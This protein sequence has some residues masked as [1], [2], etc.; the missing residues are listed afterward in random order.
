MA[1]LSGLSGCSA[2]AS[3]HS[4]QA[5]ATEDK[6]A[7]SKDLKPITVLY[8]SNS[9]T[10]KAY[11]EEMETNAS[12]YGFRVHVGTVDSAT[13]HVPKDKPVLIIEP[14]YE[15][16]PADNAKKFTSW[17]QAN[18]DSNSLD[19]V[20]YA[21]FGVGNSDW[22]HT[23]HRVPKLTDELMNKMGGRRFLPFGSV[24]VKL[25]IVG[26]WEEWQDR[27]WASLRKDYG[28]TSRV[29]SSQLQA[30]ITPPKF[31]T[32]LGGSDIGY[33]VVKVNR[34]L[35]GAEVG[36][37]KKHM[38]IELPIGTS[39]RP[40]DYMVVLPLNNITMVKRVMKRFELSPNDN[41][42]VTGTNKAFIST[43]TP[44]S[45]FDLL[46]S[47]VELGTPI[48]QKQIRTLAE[49]MPEDKCANLLEVA[50][51]PLYTSNTVAKRFNIIDILEDFSECQL[52][53]ATYLDML[54]PL[55]PRQYSISSSPLAN[56]EF[57]E[58]PQGSG[59]RLTASLTYD[60]HDTGAWSGMGRRF[61]G[62]AS[63]YLARQEPGEK[64]RCFTRA[65]NV[66]FHLPLDPTIPIIMVCAG[67]G[68][69][70]MRG[71]IQE[72]ATIQKARNI[73]LGPA[74]LYFGCRNYEF[75]YIYADELRQWETDGVV[76]VR[77]CFSQNA[78]A[79]AS[80]QHVPDQMWTDREEL[81]ELFGERKGKIFICGS[82]SKLAKSTAE[83]C[84][85][86]WLERNKGLSEEDAQKW[87]D[88]VKEDRYVTDVYD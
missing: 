27:V 54:K 71:F 74:V 68:F 37:K 39:Y 22:A 21:V 41:I 5:K 75:D 42:A 12:R 13:E 33:G 66:N 85:K 23:F 2:S 53:F 29:A 35:C 20:T 8:G 17:L 1:S 58:T 73:T 63:T 81:A 47:R 61:Y 80:T 59:Q 78:P 72:R 65:T 60:V 62:A 9:G 56:V 4:E 10:C 64:V 51:D 83:V 18:A 84:K 24:D 79:G 88:G 67:S 46:M 36:L 30:Q 69:A 50:T 76:S 14:S 49:F 57:L 3:A 48:S 82:A 31:A 26:P 11:A 19:G 25:D 52:P 32:N 44:I 16:L 55:V 7:L 34:D 40:G 15:G 87:L 38:E 77:P 45:I 43:D 86:I 70:P 28:T 6:K